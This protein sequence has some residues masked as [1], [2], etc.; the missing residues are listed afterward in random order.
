MTLLSEL[1]TW[2]LEN[3]LGLSVASQIGEVVHFFIFATLEIF[4]LMSLII[5]GIGLLRSFIDPLKKAH[6]KH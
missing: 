3:V 5:M 4:V 2:L 1:I 6:R